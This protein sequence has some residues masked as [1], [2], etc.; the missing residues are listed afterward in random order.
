MAQYDLP[1]RPPKRDNVS[2]RPI[3]QPGPSKL[4]RVINNRE[5]G[6]PYSVLSRG[7]KR[8]LLFLALSAVAQQGM[9]DTVNLEL[10]Y[11][12]TFPILEEQPLSVQITA[13]IPGEAEV[14]VPTGD[15]FIDAIAT[16]S[17]ES[18]NG[19]N[20]VG[21][22]TLQ[23]SVAA[24]S[25]ISGPGIGLDL[26]V[27]M[28]ITELSLPTESGAF[29]TEASGSTPSLSF[30][31]S[32][33][34]DIEVTVGDLVMSLEPRDQNG[35]LTGLGPFESECSLNAGQNPLLQT[36]TVTGEQSGPEQIQ[37]DG[38]GQLQMAE[39]GASASLNTTLSATV[40]NDTIT[41][42][43]LNLGDTSLDVKIISFFNTLSL[44]TD[45][46]FGP[47][48]NLT[49][50]ASDEGLVIST[51]TDI[52]LTK[53]QLK[54]FGIRLAEGGSSECKTTQPA[55]IELSSAN[56][57]WT[58]PNSAFV[59]EGTLTVPAFADCGNMTNTVNRYLVGQHAIELNMTTGD[60]Q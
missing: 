55:T 37:A 42:G 47:A 24:G 49:G 45:L 20:F 54:M 33:I 23:G 13:D 60:G 12:C 38:S 35:Q 44:D 43:Q 15:F 6:M 5:T 40:E 19:L 50:T 28:D 9:A 52:T 32:N 58:T 30:S 4:N 22:T 26:T 2:D 17:E 16:V 29:D 21:T 34:G 48:S 31:E 57:D 14:G 8:P 3:M 39:E 56:G 36:I 7:L 46:T 53:A 11:T 10:D 41:G 1:L 27:P 18:W 59:L 25:R 51:Q